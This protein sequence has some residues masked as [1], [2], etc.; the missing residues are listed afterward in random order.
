MRST[1]YFWGKILT[2]QKETFRRQTCTAESTNKIAKAAQRAVTLL[3]RQP[4]IK[5]P[6]TKVLLQPESSKKKLPKPWQISGKPFHYTCYP[7]IVYP[8]GVSFTP[9]SLFY[10]APRTYAHT[11]E[12]GDKTLPHPAQQ[13]KQPGIFPAIC[14]LDS[15]PSLL[16]PTKIILAVRLHFPHAALLLSNIERFCFLANTILFTRYLSPAAGYPKAP[17]PLTFTGLNLS[18]L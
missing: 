17:L 5:L 2:K 13:N 18:V 10:W 8:F 3:T 4:S 1:K 14:S 15:L 16:S 7:S 11:G 6:T 9:A 12:G